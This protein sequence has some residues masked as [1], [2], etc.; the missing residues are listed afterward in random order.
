[1]S[2]QDNFYLEKESNAFYD[3]WAA[4][5]SFLQAGK[6]KLR[7][8]KKEILEQLQSNIDIEK[9]EVLEIGCFVGDLLGKFKSDHGCTVYGVESSSKACEFAKENFDVT[10]ENN[11]F[12][13]SSLFTLNYENR[14]RFDIIICDDVLSWMER[15]LILPSLGLIDWMLKPGGSVYLRDFSPTFGFA[16][17]NHHWKGQKIYNFKQPSGHRYFFLTTGKYIEKST[18]VRTDPKYQ[19]VITERPDSMTWA[20]SILTKIDGS[21]HPIQDLK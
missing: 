17:E 4:S 19:R 2:H 1:M 21:L 8:E 6:G 20:D 3:R 12:A 9:K 15:D 13:K 18:Y 11:T 7:P 10:L 16:F 14:Y 5:D